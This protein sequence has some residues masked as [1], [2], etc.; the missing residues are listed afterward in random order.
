MDYLVR[1]AIRKVSSLCMEINIPTRARKIAAE[2]SL[3][4][5]GI[6]LKKKKK[7]RKLVRKKKKTTLKS[8]LLF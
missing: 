5:V 3:L 7:E 6:F 2:V 4:T 1:S 8:L